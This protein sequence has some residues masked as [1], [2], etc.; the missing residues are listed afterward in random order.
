MSILVLSDALTALP[1]SCSALQSEVGEAGCFSSAFLSD[2]SLADG[3]YLL[4]SSDAVH[5]SPNPEQVSVQESFLTEKTIAAYRLFDEKSLRALLEGNQV[6]T[7]REERLETTVR[8]HLLGR[9]NVQESDLE[10][11]LSILKI[12][13]PHYHESALSYLDQKNY[14]KS[15]AWFMEASLAKEFAGFVRSVAQAFLDGFDL[16]KVD[17]GRVRSL[18]TFFPLL[19]TAYLNAPPS[20][21][22]K[23]LGSVSILNAS[24]EL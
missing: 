8:T 17:V 1:P 19:F 21:R 15:V 3:E 12:R 9:L 2:V 7:C 4:F 10:T 11:L 16:G 6:L 22:V 5:L 23:R 14:L 18:R 20:L 13:Y 24:T